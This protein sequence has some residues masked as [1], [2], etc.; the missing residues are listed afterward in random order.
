MAQ[1]EQLLDV[2]GDIAGHTG[3]PITILKA[4]ESTLAAWVS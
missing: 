3:P 1:T 4:R 2:L